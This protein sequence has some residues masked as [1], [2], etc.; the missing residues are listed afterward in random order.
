MKTSIPRHGGIHDLGPLVDAPDQVFNFVE[1]VT[2][3]K[4]LTSHHAANAGLAVKNGFGIRNQPE[5]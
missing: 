1:A 4:N 2:L 3:A 5:R